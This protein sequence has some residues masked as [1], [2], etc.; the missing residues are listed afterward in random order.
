MKK[1]KNQN[2]GEVIPLK[3]G[4]RFHK[5]LD[6]LNSA[7]LLKAT[8]DKERIGMSDGKFKRCKFIFQNNKYHGILDYD[9]WL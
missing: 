9:A 4:N 5:T 6:E 1:T 2:N 3:W 7:E 8:A